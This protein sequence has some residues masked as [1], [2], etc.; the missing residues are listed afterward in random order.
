MAPRKRKAEETLATMS[1][2]LARVTRLAARVNHSLVKSSGSMFIELPD[3][4]K[5]LIKKKETKMLKRKVKKVLQ[6]KVRKRKNTLKKVQEAS[7]A[8]GE[9]SKKVLRLKVRKRKKK[10]LRTFKKFRG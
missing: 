4:R 1:A 8:E 2:M 6:L 9:I 5:S 7:K 3:R 10:T